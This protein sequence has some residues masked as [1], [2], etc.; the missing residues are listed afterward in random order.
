VGGGAMVLGVV[1]YAY[2]RNKKTQAAANAAAATSSAAANGTLAGTGAGDSG[3][4]PNTG[5]PYASESG[6]GVGTY[7]GIDPATGV[8]YY[9]EITQSSTTTNPNAITTNSA[10]IEQAESD[11][12]NLFGATDAVAVSAVGKYMAQTSAGLNSAEYLLM[13]QI[14]A[15]LGQPP[16]GGPYRFIQASGSGGTTTTGGGS[17]TL[18]N[19]V[20]KVVNLNAGVKAFGNVQGLATHFGESVAHLQ[21]LN[22]GISA[23]Q[24]SGTVVVP[25]LI[26]QGMSLASLSAKFEESE[27]N[28]AQQLSSQGIV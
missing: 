10:W 3:I 6:D 11:G 4:D 15:E 21:L 19:S 7:G 24:T 5:L 28:I 23:G 26:T 25:V 16:T 22:P 9:D 2:Y 27:E 8:P 13:Q 12:Q 1:G 20:G 17:T 14:V 18:A